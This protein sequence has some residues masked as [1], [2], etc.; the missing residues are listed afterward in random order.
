LTLSPIQTGTGGTGARLDH[1]L[2]VAWYWVLPNVRAHNRKKL[3]PAF[4][5]SH[6]FPGEEEIRAM[7]DSGVNVISTMDD[8]DYKHQTVNHWHDGEFP[9]YPP[10]KMKELSRFIKR[11]HSCD[12]SVIPYFAGRILSTET[13][14]FAAHARDWYASAIPEGQLRYHPAAMAGTQGLFVCSDS[15]WNRYLEGYIKRCVDELGFDGYYFDYGTPG[16]CFNTRHMPGEHTMTDGLVSLVENLRDWLGD[17]RLMIGH[18]GA[19]ACWLMLH[20]IADGIVTLEE[21]KK[22]GGTF[23]RIEDY[24]P[25]IAFMGSAS[26]SLVPNVFFSR[27]EFKDKQLLLHEGVAHAALLDTVI[28]PYTFWYEAFGY[29]HWREALADPDGLYALYRKLKD[30]D[31]TQYKYFSP[32]SGV[33]RANRRSVRAA[34]YVGKDD[35]IVVAANVGPRPVAGA[36]VKLRISGAKGVIGKT[37][38]IG[39]LKSNGVVVR[40]LRLL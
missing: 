25:S 39:T 20:N 4:F 38:A 19:N 10:E 22:D 18:C 5:G 8:V 6:P 26:V 37:V 35:A 34:V 1:P 2:E 33:T 21:G 24:P 30:I 36:T 28:Y 29:K 31:F 15:G 40:K 32:M 3:F 23:R 13:R 7:A 16:A 12:I 11:C 9:P 14:A 17:D 27:P